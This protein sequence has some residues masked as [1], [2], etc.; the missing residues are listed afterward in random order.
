MRVNNALHTAHASSPTGRL[1]RASVMGDVTMVSCQSV[2]T[3][4]RTIA[5]DW[6]TPAADHRQRGALVCQEHLAKVRCGVLQPTGA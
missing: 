3:W 1:C 2:C 5:R 6:T 4:G